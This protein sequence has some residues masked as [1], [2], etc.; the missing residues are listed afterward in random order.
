MPRVIEIP[1]VPVTVTEKLKV[2]TGRKEAKESGGVPVEEEWMQVL[3]KNLVSAIAL[4]GA[5]KVFKLFI[6]AYV[7]ELQGEKR[8]AL[9][10]QLPGK[11]RK[12][13]AYLESLEM[14]D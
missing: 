5:K 14:E 10:P 7:V 12:K 1:D 4:L 11:G 9:Q 8:Q 6:N 3:P 2:S 13:A